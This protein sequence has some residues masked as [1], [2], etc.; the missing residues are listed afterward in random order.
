MPT[1]QVDRKADDAP[2]EDKSVTREP[3]GGAIADR[4]VMLTEPE[5]ARQAREDA[6]EADEELRE[7]QR[8][9]LDAQRSNIKD[10]VVVTAFA[11]SDDPEDAPSLV[12]ST[13]GG[14]VTVYASSPEMTFGRANV[15]ALTRAIQKV[16]AEAL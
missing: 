4:P 8:A 11:D 7:L 1:K 15:L 5:S 14:E 2:P 12:F 6:I 13:A 9:T 16:S 3:E 10:P